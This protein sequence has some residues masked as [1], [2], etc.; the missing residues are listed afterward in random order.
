MFSLNWAETPDFQHMPRRSVH[1]HVCNGRCRQGPFFTICI[2]SI[3]TINF[4]ALHIERR[5]YVVVATWL[6]QQLIGCG[7]GL[8]YL[9]F[10]VEFKQAMVQRADFPVKQGL[11]ERRGQSVIL[12]RNLMSTLGNRELVQAANE[13]AADTG[14][15]HVPLAEGQRVAGIDRRSVALN[16]GR[17]A[18]LD[19]GMG[20]SLV[21]WK[22]I[23]E[24]RLGKQLAATVR[25]SGLSWDI[26][27]QRGQAVG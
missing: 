1:H 14:L 3:P 24:Q 9:G 18:M 15:A 22:P 13:I 6:N 23:I 16:S 10:G 20:F 12:A 2:V 4:F 7:Q 26:V 21:P 25:S 11:A 19:D 5:A 17:Y 8:S 27:R